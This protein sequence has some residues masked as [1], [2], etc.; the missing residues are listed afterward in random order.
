ML[1]SN[2]LK[3]NNPKSK[4]KKKNP[5]NKSPRNNNLKLNQPLNPSQPK[6]QDQSLKH[7]ELILEPASKENKP[8]SQCPDS[9]KESPKDLNKH[10]I[11]TLF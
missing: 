3:N 6:I 5:E 4:L 2:R 7:P 11:T 8:E 1:Q 9:D 10:K